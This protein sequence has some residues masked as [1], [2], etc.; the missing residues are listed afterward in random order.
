VT[1]SFDIL[2]NRLPAESGKKI[3]ERV[4]IT[5]EDMPLA[6]LRQTRKFTQ[7]QIAKTLKINQASVSKMESQSDM[8]L[9]TIRKYI[10]A[11]GGELEIVAKFPEERI[12]VE[13]IENLEP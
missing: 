13:K 11:L 6:E 1:K 12:K 2:K 4:K 5:L 9:S 8:Y 7:Q 3:E 10:E